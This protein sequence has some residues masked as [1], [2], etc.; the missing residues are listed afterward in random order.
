MSITDPLVGSQLGDYRIQ[1]LLGRGGMARVYRGYD[2]KL[3]RYA[4]VKVIDAAQAIEPEDEYRQR[5]QREARAIARLNHPN[6]VGVYQFG[7]SGSIYYMAMAFIEGRDLGQVLWAYER[8]GRLMPY[9]DILR[10]MRDLASALDHAHSGG[11]IHR[12]IKPSNI[13]VTL[14]GHAVLTDFGLALSVPEGSMGNTF[15]S[16]HYVAPEQA[17]AS[18]AA[19]PQSDFYSLGVVL[20]LMLTGR[21]PFDDPSAMAVVLKHLNEPPPPPRALNAKIPSQV[22]A[23]LLR[24]LEKDPTKRYRSGKEMLRALER[25]F[26]AAGDNT[27]LRRPSELEQAVAAQPPVS[28][29]ARTRSTRQSQPSAAVI[30]NGSDDNRRRRFATLLTMLAVLA[31][32]AGVVLMLNGS[33]PPATAGTAI[34][35]G[36]PSRPETEMPASPETATLPAAAGAQQTSEATAPVVAAAAALT[37][38]PPSETSPPTA[39][40]AP[41][42]TPPAVSPMPTVSSTLQDPALAST[43]SNGGSVDLRFDDTMLVIYN[44]TRGAVDLSNLQFVQTTP[45]GSLTFRS[46]LWGNAEAL[47]PQACFQIWTNHY[48]ELPAPD[49]CQIRQSWRSVSFV[50]WFWLSD[51]P[52]ASF[53]VRRGDHVLAR[54]AISAGA[55]ALNLAT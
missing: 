41:T 52:N 47:Q 3:D 35:T 10:L 38:I 33:N 30:V 22:E 25:A 44:G 13:M 36:L 1:D 55:C 7:E 17:V 5:F 24:M 49:Y 42:S 21:V 34:M 16:A 9:R 11:V 37:A 45:D 4:A 48:L 14:D 18:A 40:L 15:G 12:D 20:Y 54:C 8:E 32:G 39:T 6:I 19:V 50:R 26:E 23:V 2:E 31:V 51:D 53:E 27:D 28:L 43:L 29:T 46:N